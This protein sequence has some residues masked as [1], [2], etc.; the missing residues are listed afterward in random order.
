METLL[1][2]NC[3]MIREL[4]RLRYDIY[5]PADLF[6][7]NKHTVL[8]GVVKPPCCRRCALEEEDAS[9]G[10]LVAQEGG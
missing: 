6:V 8:W 1:D 2:S 4:A 3:M 9:G 5:P 10:T 7:F